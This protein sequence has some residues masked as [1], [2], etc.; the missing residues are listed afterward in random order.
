MSS[1]TQ[2]YTGSKFFCSEPNIV[3]LVPSRVHE[4]LLLTPSSN[5]PLLNCYHNLCAVNY[6]N[7]HILAPK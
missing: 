1:I 4:L 5:Y 6:T 2:T 3:W 7:T